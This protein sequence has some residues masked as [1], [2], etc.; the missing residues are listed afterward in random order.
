[1]R[2]DILFGINTKFLTKEIHALLS[3]VADCIVTSDEWI[4]YE[5]YSVRTRVLIELGKLTDTISMNEFCIIEFGDDVTDIS[6][7][8]T[9]S[10]VYIK[11]CWEYDN[12][13]NQFE[14][15]DINIE[16]LLIKNMGETY[17]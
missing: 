3:D 8:G 15:N 13:V 9:P 7:T 5:M 17:E 6:V 12:D 4:Y 14:V 2:S 1:M 16:Q 11:R 10:N